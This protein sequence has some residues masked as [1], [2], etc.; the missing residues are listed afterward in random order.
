M[1]SIW[2]NPPFTKRDGKPKATFEMGLSPVEL[3]SWL[4]PASDHPRMAEK[5]A[6][7]SD[8]SKVTYHAARQHLGDVQHAEVVVSRAVMDFA[9]EVG[10]KSDSP[11]VAAS[12]RVFDDL[13]ILD[14]DASS[15]VLISGCVASPSYWRLEDKIG[16]PIRDVHAPAVGLN[17]KLGRRIDEFIRRL[18]DDRLFERRNWFV[19]TSDALYQHDPQPQED[20]RSDPLFLRS[21]RQTLRGFG[22]WVCFSIAVST[23]PLAELDDNPVAAVAL[24]QALSH[25]S[26]AEL[27]HFGGFEKRRAILARLP[28]A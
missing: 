7:L 5:L 19:H 15:P 6:N 17:E 4:S 23:H 28:Q 9:G 1:S 11:L 14:R 10:H 24:R 18:P 8:I 3:N 2:R 22:R 20:F 12:H 25:L 16:R 21:E 26:E 27:E 13:C